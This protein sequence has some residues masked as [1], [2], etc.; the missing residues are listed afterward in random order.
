MSRL[1]TLVSGKAASAQQK[2]HVLLGLFAAT[3]FSL[4]LVIVGTDYTV[5]L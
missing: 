1:K 5:A 4:F 2:Y 3:L